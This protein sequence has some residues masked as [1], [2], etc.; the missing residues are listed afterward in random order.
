MTVF[1]KKKKSSQMSVHDVMHNTL[2]LLNWK[3]GLYAGLILLRSILDYQLNTF[4]VGSQKQN[5]K[6]RWAIERERE[7][8]KENF[9]DI[10]VGG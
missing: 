3:L 2:G 4:W 5:T 9:E 8:R 1:E 6:Q 10:Y 7:R